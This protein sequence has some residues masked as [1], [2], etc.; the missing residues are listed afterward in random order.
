MLIVPRVSVGKVKAGMTPAQV[1]AELG[2]SQTKQGKILNYV[3]SGFSVIPNRDGVVV[4]VMCGDPSSIDSP[5]VKA[6][7]G[8]TAEGIGMRSTRDEVLKAYGKPD[9]TDTPE[10]GHERLKYDD[11]GL[12]FILQDLKVHHI[13]V[14]LRPAK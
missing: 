1:V 11:L 13:T 14:N 4:V 10:P 7:T 9:E 3:R 8:R 12:A 5:L 2:E 6:F